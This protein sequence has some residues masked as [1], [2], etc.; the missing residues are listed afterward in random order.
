MIKSF[1]ESIN[2]SNPVQR[3]CVT[4]ADFCV[5]K[6]RPQWRRNWRQLWYAE[7]WRIGFQKVATIS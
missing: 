5:N 6:F 2:I 1:I 7:T 3:F 4:Y